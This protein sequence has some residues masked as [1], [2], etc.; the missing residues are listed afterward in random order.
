MMS[1]WERTLISVE[2]WSHRTNL[3]VSYSG[4]QGPVGIAGEG[5][6]KHY[7]LGAGEGGLLF[8]NLL[9]AHHQE[10]HPDPLP[11]FL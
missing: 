3:F 10:V 4:F 11:R 8:W 6:D 9:Q 2:G 1:S 7:S 5:E